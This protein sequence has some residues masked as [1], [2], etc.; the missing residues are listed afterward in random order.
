MYSG[1]IP[2]NEELRDVCG[3]YTQN[4]ED[5]ECNCM[6][7]EYLAN[8]KNNFFNKNGGNAYGD[9]DGGGE[10]YLYESSTYHDGYY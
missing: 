2:M 8:L 9:D 6:R 7:E 3:Y 4:F 1:D 5:Y 10:R